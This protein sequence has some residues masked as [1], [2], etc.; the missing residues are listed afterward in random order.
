MKYDQY[1]NVKP[2]SVVIGSDHLR[3]AL[4]K[5]DTLAAKLV[6]YM[7]WE[8]LSRENDTLREIVAPAQPSST[9]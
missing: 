7:C 3:I 1:A 4:G 5:F 2:C 8:I 9:K 6:E